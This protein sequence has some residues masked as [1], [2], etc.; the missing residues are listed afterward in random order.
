MRNEPFDPKKNIL[1]SSAQVDDGCTS[2]L[3]GIV[4]VIII[5]AIAWIMGP[6]WQVT[7]TFGHG[8]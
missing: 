7:D 6:L 3:I 5:L 2:I 8:L 1:G 4:T